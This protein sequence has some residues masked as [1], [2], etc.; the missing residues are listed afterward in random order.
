MRN[1]TE[2]IVE[3]TDILQDIFLADTIVLSESTTAA[4][5]EGWDSFKQIEIILAAEARWGIRFSPRELDG[6]R[7]IGDLARVIAAKAA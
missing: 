4:D 7:S 6:L 3:L 1:S 5:V 2:I